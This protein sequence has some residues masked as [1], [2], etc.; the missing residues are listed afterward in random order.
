MHWSCIWFLWLDGTTSDRKHVWAGTVRTT[1]RRQTTGGTAADNLY[2]FFQ[3]DFQTKTRI[4][5]EHESPFLWDRLHP[6]PPA[7]LVEVGG[8]LRR[9]GAMPVDASQG[10]EQVHE[11]YFWL[12]LIFSWKTR[13]WI[14]ASLV[15]VTWL[16]VLEA[17]VIFSRLNTQGHCLY[18]QVPTECNRINR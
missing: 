13:Q 6:R 5:S 16:K 2:F 18:F 11:L 7:S 4:R 10:R 14:T 9:P 1:W 15:R 12:R 8:G 17:N 3:D